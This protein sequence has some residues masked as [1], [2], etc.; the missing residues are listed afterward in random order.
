SIA[1]T[2]IGGKLLVTGS[3]AG[4]TTTARSTI[5]APG[6]AAGL[7][8]G[9]TLGGTGTIGGT[10]AISSTTATNQGG[11]LFPGLGGNTA[12][13]LNVAAMT[14]N[15]FG[16]YVFQYDSNNTTT[17]GGV[18]GLV[19]GTG[20]LNLTNLGNVTPGTPSATPFDL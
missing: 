13:T 10:V 11:I 9:G 2:T 12:G 7:G 15:P 19:N 3:I 17:G 8:L 4:G 1:G 5:A 6:G 20:T 14:W 16:R 18:N